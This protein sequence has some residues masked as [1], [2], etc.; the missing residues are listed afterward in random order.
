MVFGMFRKA[1]GLVYWLTKQRQFWARNRKVGLIAWGA[2]DWLK[3]ACEF[4]IAFLVVTKILHDHLG[5]IGVFS[6]PNGLLAER[7]W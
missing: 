4:I 7:L 6:F 1:E 5:R 3:D 2:V